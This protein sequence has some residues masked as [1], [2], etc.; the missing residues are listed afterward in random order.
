MTHESI[1]SLIS[2]NRQGNYS[3]SVEHG[4]RAIALNPTMPEA[5]INLGGAYLNLFMRDK[6][7]KMYLKALE[8]R[9]GFFIAYASLGSLES[10]EG[11]VSF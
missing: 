2:F 6:A 7:R 5:Y 11:H 8:L 3:K 10:E 1:I 4:E 9:P